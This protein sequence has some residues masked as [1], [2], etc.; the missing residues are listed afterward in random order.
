MGY[1]SGDEQ[2]NDYKSR[3]GSIHNKKLRSTWRNIALHGG[4]KNWTME[5]EKIG[6]GCNDSVMAKFCLVMMLSSTKIGFLNDLGYEVV[7]G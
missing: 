3:H 5:V 2:T 6:D 7:F 4:N 1:N